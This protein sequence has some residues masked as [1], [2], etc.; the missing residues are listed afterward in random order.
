MSDV[1]RDGPIE[2]EVVVANRE[3]LHF[4]P[5]MQF[6]DLAGKFKCRLTVHCNDHVADG[7]SPM[8]LLMLVGVKGSN[9]KLV[10]QGDD[11]L[12]AVNALT[13]LVESGFGEA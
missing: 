7:R 3:G 10:A 5:I 1:S 9:L 8:E 11:A 6:V 13:R 4:R 12:A 2:R